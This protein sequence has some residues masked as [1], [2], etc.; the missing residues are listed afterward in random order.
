VNQEKNSNKKRDSVRSVKNIFSKHLWMLVKLVE[1]ML[2]TLWIRIRTPT[3]KNC[4]NESKIRL[5]HKIRLFMPIFLP[6]GFL[7]KKHA[8]MGTF[9]NKFVSLFLTKKFPQLV[10]SRKKPFPTNS[11]HK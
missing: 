7:T 2:C 10:N 11:A 3:D 6:P 9:L 5:T 8:K 1:K 4:G